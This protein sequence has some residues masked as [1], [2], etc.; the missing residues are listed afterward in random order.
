LH[1]WTVGL[2]SCS[3]VDIVY[4]DFSKAFDSIVISKLLFKLELYGISGHLL[5]WISCFLSN[6]LQC[7]VID[8]FYSHICPVVSGV[9]QGSVLG[10]ILFIIYINDIDS[11]CCGDAKMQLFADDAKLYSNVVINNSSVS[12]QLSLD[13][14]AH[15]AKEWQLTI[16]INKCSVLSLS[17]SV[18]SSSRQYS[19][20]GVA[21]P[22]QNSYVDLGVTVIRN[23]SFEA[24]IENIVSKARQRISILFRGFITRNLGLMRRA[25]IAYIRPILEYNSVVWNPC[26]TYLIDKLENVQRNFSKRIPSLSA[27]SYLERL[28]LL[29]LEPLELRRLRFDLIYYFKVY[30]H[31]T[32]FDPDAVFLIYTP[33]PSSRANSP[34]LQK[35][36]KASNKLLHSLFYR[37]TD[38]WNALPVALRLTS[39][40]PE[41]KRGLKIFDLSHFLKGSA[42]H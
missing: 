31:L 30:N 8:R 2:N 16:N 1:D 10:P 13:R 11:V 4:I 29:D 25:F 28:A 37:N 39:S 24:H 19:I 38:A 12:L 41:F 6:R 40:L 21:I 33:L 5:K 27:L 22:C 23:L 18:H 17:T 9:P 26:Y 36:T 3:H 14:L 15:W 42:L 32:P 7:V 35:P 20:G 34:Y